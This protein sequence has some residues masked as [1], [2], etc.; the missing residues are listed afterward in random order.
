VG[1]E[2]K[3]VKGIRGR[4][5][6][7]SDLD[8]YHIRPLRT[9]ALYFNSRYAQRGGDCEA[10]WWESSIPPSKKGISAAQS[11]GNHDLKLGTKG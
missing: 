2:G 10:G 8:V 1:T 11:L 3:G 5:I 9:K 6:K 7:F 4:N